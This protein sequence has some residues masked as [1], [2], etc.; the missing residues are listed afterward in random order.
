M[1]PVGGATAVID[2]SCGVILRIF[3]ASGFGHHSRVQFAVR[4]SRALQPTALFGEL[5]LRPRDLP[6]WI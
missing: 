5:F 2:V 1:P 6:G 4:A 3:K